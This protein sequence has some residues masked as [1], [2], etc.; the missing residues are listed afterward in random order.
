MK[1]EEALGFRFRVLVKASLA[2]ESSVACLREL[3]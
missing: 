1:A 2:V 3:L